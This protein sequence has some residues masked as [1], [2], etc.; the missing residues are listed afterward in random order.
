MLELTILVSI[1]LGKYLEVYI[2]TALLAFNAV[3]GSIQE[4]QAA[5]AV[6]ALRS[7]LKVNAR[8]LRDGEWKIVPAR[9]LVPGDVLRLRAGDFVPADL[10]VGSGQL[11]V[12]QSS[13]TGESLPVTKGPGETL[14]SGSVVRVGESTAL[15]LSTGRATYFGKTTELVQLAKPRFQLEGITSSV[16]KWL[17]LMVGTLLAATFI[18]SML[19]GMNA[20]DLLPLALVLLVSAIPVALPTMFVVSMALGSVE[21]AKKGVLI[22]RLSAVEDAATMDTLCVD[23]TGTITMN[24]LEITKVVP[25]AGFSEEDVVVLGALASNVANQD[26]IDLAFL[27]AS[28]ARHSLFSSFRQKE[29]MPFSPAT[30]RTE[31]VADDGVRSI[32]CI[33]GAVNTITDVCELGGKECAE[34]EEDTQKLAVS[35]YRVLAVAVAEG[36]AVPRVVGLVALW[37]PPRKE[38]P[39]LV[40]ELRDLGISVK[41]L[42]GDAAPVAEEMAASIGLDAGIVRATDLKALSEKDPEKAAELSESSS[43]FAEI[44]PEDKYVIVKE[45]QSKG[46]VVGMTGDGVNDAPA[47]KQA[48]VGIAVSNATDVAKSAASAVLTDEGLTHIV[49]LVSTGRMIY[50]RVIVWIV[51]KIVKTFEVV[52]FASLAFILTGDIVVGAFQIVLLLFVND[53]VTISLSTDRVRPSKRPETWKISGLVRVAVILGVL[54]VAEHFL[55]LYLGLRYLDL[56]SDIS[57]LNTF[58]FAMLFFSGMLVLFMVRERGRFWSSSPSKVLLGAVALD[59]LL[60]TLLCTLGIPGLTPIPLADILFIVAYYAFFVLVVDDSVKCMLV[61][62]AELSW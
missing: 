38:S 45:L 5:S 58:G 12:D 53:F 35:G 47:L 4:A 33:K 23:K 24:S 37:D 36:R 2:I 43:G 57:A 1:L 27:K 21:L 16:V 59:V 50:E 51:N 6:R 22:T 62:R 61:K 56:G 55:L 26:P 41:M 46:H 30:K 19:R 34:I 49:D 52:V 20:I 48:E 11:E 28:S 42:T 17:L 25:M 10:K 44:F 9:D 13:L 39:A 32:R 18:A 60:V 29:F 31:A 14:Y 7:K 54:T 15:V 40:K 8:V 3:L